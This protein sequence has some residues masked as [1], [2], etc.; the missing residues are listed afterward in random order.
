MALNL[1][2]LH[3]VLDGYFDAAEKSDF[4]VKVLPLDMSPFELPVWLTRIAPIFFKK[5]VFIYSH[6]RFAFSVIPVFHKHDMVIVREFLTIPL[7]ISWPFLFLFR[8]KLL[9]VVNH[10]VQFMVS[11]K[12]QR[13]AFG[14]L[15]RLG[16][17]YVFLE[18][19]AG[20]EMSLTQDVI[21]DCLVLPI[22][23]QDMERAN[24]EVVVKT[25]KIVV[26]VIG[27]F[28]EEKGNKELLNYLV[29]FSVAET[30]DVCWELLVGTSDLEVQRWCFN[31]GLKVID[32]K[33]FSEYGR[34]YKECDLVILNY[35]ESAYY[36]R[37]SGAVCDAIVGRAVIL[38]PEYPV[39]K[40]Q[41]SK[42]GTVGEFFSKL[43]DVPAKIDRISSDLHCFNEGFSSQISERSVNGIKDKIDLFLKGRTCDKSTT[44]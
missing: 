12:V 15:A 27:D 16:V 13:Y 34:A 10:N 14:L 23:A 42:Y 33:E 19:S 5:L 4:K 40:Q 6:I 18:S 32:T 21:D 31:K 17:R 41:I 25:G 36:Y 1:S 29:N 37:S 24:E 28:R 22:P 43:T 20:S 2:Q 30:E 44:W 11:N 8:R 7:L 38:C 35:Q 39:L 3:R 9:F 26:G